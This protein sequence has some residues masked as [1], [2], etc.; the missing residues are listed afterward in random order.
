MFVSTYVGLC[1]ALRQHVRPHLY[2]DLNLNL[3]LYLYLYLNL[4]LNLFL[5]R[6]P[7][8]KPVAASFGSSFDLKYR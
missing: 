4:N 5:F 3:Y 8:Q 2:L 6:K 7:F 1:R